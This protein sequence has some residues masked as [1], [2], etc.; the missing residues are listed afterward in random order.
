MAGCLSR[1]TTWVRYIKQSQI[2]LKAW[3]LTEMHPFQAVSG[4][5]A[6]S[7]LG[8][9]ELLSGHW[10]ELRTYLAVAKSGSV[11]RA[12]EQLGMSR[13][14]VKGHVTR[15]QDVMGT[16]LVVSTRSGVALTEKGSDLAREL[17]RIDHHLLA[18]TREVTASRGVPQGVVRVG[19]PDGLGLVFLIPALKAFSAR[20]P[21]I[22]IRL[23]T[24][25]NYRSL[26]E[27]TTD[28]IVGF[29]PDERKDAESVKLGWLH[30]MP[31]ASRGYIDERGLPTVDNLEEHDFLD[32]DKY[33]A[34]V[35][36]WQEWQAVVKRGRTRHLSDSPII[37]AMMVK[38]GLG[39]G[40]LASYTLQ[41]T[42]A[43]ALD[44]GAL[45]RL[46]LYA[47]FL[48]DQSETKPVSIV[49]EFLAETLAPTQRWLGETL[50]R[51]VGKDPGLALFLDR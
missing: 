32:S 48:A 40:L 34:P 19:C 9:P 36:P 11:S 4:S 14:T 33:A 3:D 10:T 5:V 39:I 42:D 20:Y 41:D 43:V 12:A 18:L 38:A 30:L 17:A 25:S 22:Q 45:I 29:S 15:L 28:C 21:G 31:I 6:G 7:A 24:L 51:E 44:I 26:R 49:R 46:P 8:Q 2:A 1:V 16:R 37:Y 50:T 13:A 35:P 23:S 27:N 47:V